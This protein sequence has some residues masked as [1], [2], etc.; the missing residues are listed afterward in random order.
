MTT[1]LHLAAA[2]PTTTV[3]TTQPVLGHPITAVDW[4]IAA[5]VLAG[6]IV[7]GRLSRTLITRTMKKGDTELAAAALIGRFTGYFFFLA[8]LVYALSVLSIHLG[9]L[10]GALGIGGLAV[11]F[12]AQSILENFMSSI[13]L[14][15]RRPFRRGDQILTNGLDGTVEEVNFRTVS[16]LTYSG[17]RVLVPSAMVLRN[18]ITNHTVL[19][20]RRTTLEIGISYDVDLP[21]TLPLI[22]ETVSHAEGVLDQPAPEAYVEEFAESTVNIAVRFWHT[23]DMANMWRVRSAVAV[24]VKSAFDEANVEMPFP[25]RVMRITQVDDP[26]QT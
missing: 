10:L 3:K 14:Q 23:P 21:S 22:I 25:Q 12:A 16:L 13:I 7:V 5:A 8:G 2:I 1:V 15:I 17:E 4:L 26:S 20:R 11:A 19:G 6:G 9:P 18:P 24:A